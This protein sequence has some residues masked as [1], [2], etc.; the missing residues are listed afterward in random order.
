MLSERDIELAHPDA[1]DFIWGNLPSAK[2]G[3]FNRHLSG[4][5]HCQAIVDEYSEIG[6]IIKLL[7]PHVEPPAGLEDRTVAAM[8]AAL[9]EQRATTDRRSDA[10][11]RTA[12]RVYPIP[13]RQPPAGHETRVQ[14]IPQLQPPAENETEPRPSP[15]DPSAP[16]EPQ[17][18]PMVT[19]LPVW[20]RYRGHLA[21]VAA[22]AAAIIAA[23]IVIPFSLGRGGLTEVVTFHLT[24]PPGSTQTASGT[25]VARP[26]ASGS[27][28]ITL[29]VRH[30]R[31]FGDSPWYECWY[32]GAGKAGHPQV[33][34]A[35]TFLVPDSGSGTF[36]MT[37][38]ADPRQFKTMQIRLEQPGATGSIQGPVV[39]TAIGKTA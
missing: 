25:A 28:T 10:E 21:A 6:Q 14:P 5:R 16:A 13:Q 22:V 9:D 11:D 1:F 18:P 30:L 36:S 26:D 27:W 23:A 33:A 31:T 19:R 35:G 8:I 17:A 4:C 32:V 29:T 34:S 15:V 7:P 37:S 39:L 12:T 3:E 38:A 24:P 2:R 20:R